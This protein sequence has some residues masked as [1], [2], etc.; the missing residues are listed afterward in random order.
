MESILKPDA[1]VAQGFPPG[2]MG[3]T[4]MGNGFYQKVNIDDLNKLVGYLLT[5]KGDQK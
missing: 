2:V 1:Q 3:A 5:L 4:L